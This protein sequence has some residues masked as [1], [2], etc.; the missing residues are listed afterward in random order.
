M[1]NENGITVKYEFGGEVNTK[2]ENVRI[3]EKVNTELAANKFKLWD[4]VKNMNSGNEWTIVEITE[5]WVKLKYKNGSAEAYND[6]SNVEIVKSKTFTELQELVTN[7][8][9]IGDKVINTKGKTWTV[10]LINENGITVKYEFGGEVNTKVENVRI[11]EKV[12]TEL[13]ANKFKLWDMLENTKSG[14]RGK[15][16]EITEN[17]VKL[18]YEGNVEA[19]SDIA[20]LKIAEKTKFDIGNEVKYINKKG[21]EVSGTI[22]EKTPTGEYPKKWSVMIETKDGTI[23]SIGKVNLET[24]I[25][26]RER[27]YSSKK[28]T[29]VIGKI[30]SLIG[31]IK[32]KMQSLAEKIKAFFS[33]PERT[34]VEEKAIVEEIKT[35]KTNAKTNEEKNIVNETESV[36]KEWQENLEIIEVVPEQKISFEKTST[37]DEVY[38][39][40]DKVW[41]IYSKDAKKT[42][43]AKEIKE[44]IRKWET[45]YIPSEWGLRSKVESLKNIKFDINKCSTQAK[46]FVREFGEPKNTIRLWDWSVLYTTDLIQS[47]PLERQDGV[48]VE[49]IWYK[50]VVWYA[51]NKGVLEPRIFYRSW[52]EWCRRSCPWA[53]T[54]DWKF[55]KAEFLNNQSYETT[56]K[57]DPTIWNKFDG[58]NVKETNQD[59]IEFSKIKFWRDFLQNQ[60][61]E[62]IKIEQRLF[63]EYDGAVQFYRGRKTADVI[64]WY[65]NLVPEWLDYTNMQVV[66]WKQ[67]SYKHDHLGEVNVT[68]CRTKFNGKDIDIHFANAKS[69]NPNQVWIE[70]IVYSGAKINSFGVYDKQINAWPLTAKPIDYATKNA[71]QVPVDANFMKY[72]NKYMDIRSLYQWNPVIKYA[73]EHV[74]GK[75]YANN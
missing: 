14:E 15:V 33:T 16:V 7:D 17:G 60:M 37:L 1:I 43:T 66:R 27:I 75:I 29:L 62:S 61:I 9:S 69:N 50:F 72:D 10:T 54:S 51:S 42:Y 31:G 40:L 4:V 65:N 56:T 53:R 22:I 34:T 70:N 36:F 23:F 21:A 41:S 58:F 11:T 20:N 3:I 5:K 12:N 38:K 25:A 49:T 46:E 63:D 71:R 32:S 68:V 8:F 13:A 67:Y 64:N 18:R 26:K 73:K 24:G 57:V 47:K 45:K 28:L 39:E 44:M 30:N 6:I 19:Y 52:S 74:L 59:I 2:V 35:Q 55:S 48:L